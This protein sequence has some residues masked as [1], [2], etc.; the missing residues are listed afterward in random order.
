MVHFLVSYGKHIRNEMEDDDPMCLFNQKWV[1]EQ[2]PKVYTTLL[3][4]IEKVYQLSETL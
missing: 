4:L 2:S 1:L 3:E